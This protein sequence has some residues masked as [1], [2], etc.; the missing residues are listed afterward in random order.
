MIAHVQPDLQGLIALLVITIGFVLYA[1][2][3][4][5]RAKSGKNDSI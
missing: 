3:T 2:W 1:S 4:E 5:R